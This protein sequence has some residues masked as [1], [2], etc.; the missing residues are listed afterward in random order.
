MK[1]DPI[2]SV[3]FI[4]IF[5]RCARYARAGDSAEYGEIP[6]ER[7]TA[8]ALPGRRK[9]TPP[10]PR[11]RRVTGSFYERHRDHSYFP[12]VKDTSRRGRALQLA[13]GSG[14]RAGRHR[15]GT[16][17]AWRLPAGRRLC[18]RDAAPCRS[19][20]RLG[21]SHQQKLMLSVRTSCTEPPK[22]RGAPSDNMVFCQ[23]RGGARAPGPSWSNAASCR[24][25]RQSP[26][27][28]APLS[29]GLAPTPAHVSG[30]A[31]PPRLKIGSSSQSC[32]VRSASIRKEMFRKIAAADGRS[33]FDLAPSGQVGA[34]RT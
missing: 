33:P 25:P 12:L 27:T 9:R 4:D 3:V 32:P 24:S 7:L 5:F 13:H 8:A 6:Q 34:F 16:P 29:P 1:S 14:S 30:P 23:V 18:V 11:G 17:S 15:R 22:I 2:R 21:P 26:H 31:I 19:P 20:N 10:P 28:S